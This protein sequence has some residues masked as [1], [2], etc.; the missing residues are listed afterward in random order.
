MKKI[1]KIL[2][3]IGKILF[4]ILFLYF[5]FYPGLV[6]YTSYITCGATC[7]AHY[8]LQGLH[9]LICVGCM[10]FILPFLVRMVKTQFKFL[11]YLFPAGIFILNYFF[12]P[13]GYSTV[14]SLFLTT[15][16]TYIC[17]I[18][19][20]KMNGWWFKNEK[21]LVLKISAVLYA[22]IYLFLMA[23]VV[24]F[25]DAYT[26]ILP[27][28]PCLSG[29]VRISGSCSCVYCG[30]VGMYDGGQKECEKCSEHEWYE[31]RCVEK[32]SEDSS[33]RDEYSRCYS[34]DTQQEI[35]TAAQECL[36]CSNRV[37]ANGLCVLP[38][39]DDSPL[40]SVSNVCYACDILNPIQTG[41]SQCTKC[42]NR[43][44]INDK[45][46]L[47]VCPDDN[48]V[49]GLDN[50]C[51]PCDFPSD[52]SA[53]EQECA[54]C[55]NRELYKGLCMQKCSEESFRDV[56]GK[57]YSCDTSSRVISVDEQ[58]CSKCSNRELYDD[59][60]MQKC[61]ES[62]PFKDGYYFRDKYYQCYSCDALQ[63]IS[64]SEQE[65]SKC[66]NR[67]MQDGKCIQAVCS[68]DNPIKALDGTCFA[69]DSPLDFK[70]T[71]QECAKCQNREMYK[72]TCAQKCSKN[73]FRDNNYKCYSCDAS[74]NVPADEEECSKCLNRKMDDNNC[75]LTPFVGNL[76]EE[77]SEI[78]MTDEITGERKKIAVSP[79]ANGCPDD[80]PMSDEMGMCSSCE[81]NY[82]RTTKEECDKCPNMR[83]YSEHTLCINRVLA[84]S[85]EKK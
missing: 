2:G 75:V 72:G 59:I 39:P 10:L 17:M 36:K 27:C 61:S 51:F 70:T 78:F 42:Q 47:S 32:C 28:P 62:F 74:K 19:W 49:R 66:P 21:W 43:E 44:M 65:C 8:S 20:F 18:I 35:K 3:K 63:G 54:R 53:S 37:M 6:M 7:N 15:F 79:N 56:R 29:E 73:S 68:K 14:T 13:R 84:D 64:V 9:Y 77:Y 23:L 26:K 76:S 48:P 5:I 33:F 69:C 31:N 60:C 16:L 82:A 46:V 1:A 50:S 83:Y 80:F 58:E 34:C 12:V 71:E 38:C 81:I 67:K 52:F 11:F 25:L 22:L 40:R 85:Y 41:Q 45:C 55:P 57:C 4:S 24:F 30:D